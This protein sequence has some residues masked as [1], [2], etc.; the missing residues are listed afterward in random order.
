M[1]KALVL[2]KVD[3]KKKT[4]SSKVDRL[5][6]REIGYTVERPEGPG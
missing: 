3:G 4:T 2:G 6:Y 1:V 5:S